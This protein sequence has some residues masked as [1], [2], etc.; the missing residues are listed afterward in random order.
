LPSLQRL[1]VF[2]GEAVDELEA[3]L[4]VARDRRDA[5]AHVG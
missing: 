3:A 5:P 1:A 2:I 4:P